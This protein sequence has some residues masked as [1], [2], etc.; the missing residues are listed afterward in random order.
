MKDNTPKPENYE[1]S[2]KIKYM[3]MEFDVVFLS[4]VRTASKAVSIDDLEEFD[5]DVSHEDED[6]MIYKK[7]SKYSYTYLFD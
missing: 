5:R 7:H 2:K 1:Y 6:S 4:V 3:D